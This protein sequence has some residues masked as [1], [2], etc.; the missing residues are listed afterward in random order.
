MK[1]SLRALAC[2]M[3]VSAVLAPSLADAGERITF[4]DIDGTQVE[5]RRCGVA[6]GPAPKEYYDVLAQTRGQVSEAAVTTIPVVFH[7][8]TSS[9]GAGF[10][11]DGQ[12]DDQIDVLNAAF[13]PS[14][15]QF[16]LFGVNR[17]S[18][19]SW[20]NIGNGS[21]AEQQMKQALAVDPANVFNM[22]ATRL[23]GGLLG[24]ATFP[25]YYPEDDY[26]HGVVV[27]NESLPGGSAVPYN[28][29][30]TATHEVGH[31]LG[32]YHTF[33]G[34]CQ[35]LGDIVRDT[36]AQRSP[37]S[38]CPVGNDTCPTRPGNDPV[39]NFMD[40]SI[41]SCMIEFTEIQ[42]AR[43]PALASRFRPS[44]FD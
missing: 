25:W 24:W 38:G 7:V 15:I 44:L 18:N 9:L 21:V 28:L 17:V 1:T 43:M 5:G 32:L 13:A 14:G 16:A 30:D 27:L 19:D 8:I 31:Y 29:G 40:Y 34:G 22:Y 23:S 2:A 4:T 20:Y 12:I 26:R 42:H 41:D 11:S 37:S 33:Q 39:F 10:I 36:P 35:G 3:A 6:D